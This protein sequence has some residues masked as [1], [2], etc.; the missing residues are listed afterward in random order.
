MVNDERVMRGGAFVEPVDKLRTGDR[1]N[2]TPSD[3]S[4]NYILGFRC[5]RPL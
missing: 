3:Q 1:G 5:A 4:T 2:N